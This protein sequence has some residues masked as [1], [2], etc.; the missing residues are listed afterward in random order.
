MLIQVVLNCII[1]GCPCKTRFGGN[2]SIN[3]VT[4]VN[5]PACVYITNCCYKPID[6]LIF[7]VMDP[8][9]LVYQ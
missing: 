8:V 7:C 9:H 1:V 6:R 2:T 3:S 5:A 4:N